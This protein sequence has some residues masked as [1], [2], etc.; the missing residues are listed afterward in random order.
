M[1]DSTYTKIKLTQAQLTEDIRIRVEV[2][3]NGEHD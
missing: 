2:T 3:L 1:K